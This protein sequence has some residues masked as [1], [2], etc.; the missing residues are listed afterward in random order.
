[1][2]FIAVWMSELQCFLEDHVLVDTVYIS[3]TR[4]CVHSTTVTLPLMRMEPL[5][6]ADAL[7]DEVHISKSFA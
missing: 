7:P 2:L 4:P 5:V 1:M 6:K 3:L